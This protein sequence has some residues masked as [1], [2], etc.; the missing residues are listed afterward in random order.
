ML[1]GFAAFCPVPGARADRPVIRPARPTVPPRLPPALQARAV[2]TWIRRPAVHAVVSPTTAALAASLRPAA[3]PVPSLAPLHPAPTGATTASAPVSGLSISSTTG[4][5]VDFDSFNF[6]DNPRLLGVRAIPPDSTAAAG[7]NHVVDLVNILLRFHQ[8]DGTLDLED[9]LQNFFAPVS[10]LTFTFDPKV[11]YDTIGGR[12]VIVTLE[13]TS[14][15]AGDAADTSRILLAV[16][17]T[18]DPNGSWTQAAIDS[19]LSFQNPNTGTVLDH[20][21]DFPG[22]AADE[23]ALYITA[24]MFTFAS[25]ASGG[26]RV[27]IVEKGAGSGGLYDGGAA[28]VSMIDPII[29]GAVATT[30]Q[31]ARIACTPPACPTPVG[32]WLAS[33]DGLNNGVDE[34]IQTLR[35]D[36]PLG[37][38]A[39]TLAFVNVGDIEN[40]SS[41][42]PDAPQPLVGVEI[43]TNDRRT[44]QA[45]WR[46]N[47]LTTVATSAPAGEATAHW[48]QIDTT[49]TPALADQGAID[50]EDIAPG[51][52]TFF[53]SVAVN[54]SGTLIIGFSAAGPSIFAGSYYAVRDSTMAAGAIGPS[55]L[56][57]RGED[58]YIRRF[59]GF[60]NRWGDYSAVATDPVDGCFWVYNQNAGPR[61]SSTSPLDDGFWET[62]L[63]KTCPDLAVCGN[64]TVEAGESCEP[65]TPGCRSDC[66]FCGD[67]F[68]DRGETCD[69]PGTPAGT[70][71]ECRADCS[72]CG[73]GFLDSGEACDDAGNAAGDGCSA[74]CR[75]EPFCGDGV[76]SAGETCDPGIDPLCSA[77]CFF[78]GDGTVNDRLRGSTGRQ[79]E[80][81]VDIDPVTATTTFL[82]PSGR[83]GQITEIEFS[84]AGQLIGATGGGLSSLVNIDPVT[85]AESLRCHHSSGILTALEFVNGV[86]HGAL[87]PPGSAGPESSLVT[88]GDPDASGICAVNVIGLTGIGAGASRENIGGLAYQ[89][90]T[91]TLFGCTASVG[92]GNLIQCDRTSGA[93]TVLFPLGFN[94]CASLEFA[95]DG[96][97]YAG[98]GGNNSTDAGALLRVDLAAMTATRVGFTGQPAL[99]GLAF[100]REGCEDGNLVDGDGCS[101]ACTLEFCVDGDGDG[102]GFPG[103]VVCPAGGAADCDDTDPAIHP[104]AVEV[105]NGVDDNCDGVTDEGFVDTDGD[106]LADCIDPDDDNDGV[107][108]VSDCAPLLAGISQPAGDAGNTLQHDG[109]QFTFLRVPQAHVFDLYTGDVVVPTDFFD[110]TCFVEQHPDTR[111]TTPAPAPGHLLYVLVD[112]TNICGD[113]GILGTTSAGASRPVGVA[114][115]FLG[116]DIDMDGVADIDDVCPLIADPAQTDTD[117]DGVGNACD[118]CPTTANPS[119]VDS[120]GDGIGD[121]CAP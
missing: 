117:R 71:A 7:P 99:S 27:W 106:G 111:F 112:P 108:D 62:A 90:S 13:K 104:G 61:G 23:E 29:S 73:D 28:T 60:S 76:V 32:T 118:N 36:D 4:P 11:I 57:R 49:T 18:S 85:G 59:G 16:S 109:Q 47:T 67:G 100:E 46:D 105:C 55:R 58:F 53:P 8:K 20:W 5:V 119:Q 50:G 78:C 72:F 102:F 41:S 110:H 98:I 88:V 14:T 21:A 30:Q 97:L 40:T 6:D 3:W 81:L 70:P 31:P 94:D 42:V 82:A 19:K 115:A 51:T 101:A 87:R 48:W 120:D 92:S 113:D 56:V 65:P 39:V 91:D 15:S 95:P 17:D 80:R 24:N 96:T 35:I 37:T 22:L 25:N 44:L 103:T 107:P 2:P 52:R 86:L 121:A 64:G 54:G 75:L 45:V 12:F 84:P 10:P 114:C 79:G 116:A 43:Q 33:Y 66:T 63:L 69:P 74:S 89:V 26:Q 1:L 34:F 83:F 38:P 9:S 93:C 68:V 77:G